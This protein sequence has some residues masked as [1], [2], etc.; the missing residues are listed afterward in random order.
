MHALN[1]TMSVMDVFLVLRRAA[2]VLVDNGK[3][4]LCRTASLPENG[5]VRKR[6]LRPGE[7][8]PA[9]ARFL[10]FPAPDT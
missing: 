1:F 8:V 4:I 7:V 3:R 5:G 2:G 6:E 9:V 10:A